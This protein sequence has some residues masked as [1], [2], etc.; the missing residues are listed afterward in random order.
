MYSWCVRRSGWYQTLIGLWALWFF[1]ALFDAGSLHTCVMHSPTVVSSGLHES[2]GAHPGGMHHT[3]PA[4]GQ[5][6]GHT[7]CTCLGTSCCASSVAAPAAVHASLAI[8]VVDV[9]AREYAE[10]IAPRIHRDFAHPFASGPPA[11]D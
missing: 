8:A 9:P 6:H 11:L 7:G 4:D 1:A 5:K 10:V 2:A 3:A